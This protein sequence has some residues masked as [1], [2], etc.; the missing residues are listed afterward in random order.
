MFLDISLRSSNHLVM[1]RE[2]RDENAPKAFPPKVCDNR[3]N[4]QPS[5]WEKNSL[6]HLI[7]HTLGSTFF[8]SFA[9]FNSP[10]YKRIPLTLGKQ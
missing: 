3:R 4:L 5:S 1:S 10:Y 7:H 6:I 9:R 8:Y 2:R